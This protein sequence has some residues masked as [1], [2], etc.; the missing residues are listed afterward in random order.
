MKLVF[1]IIGV[2]CLI[3]TYKNFFSPHPR[4]KV[5]KK[6][7]EACDYSINNPYSDWCPWDAD[8]IDG[9]CVETKPIVVKAVVVVDEEVIV[10]KKREEPS[11]IDLIWGLF[12]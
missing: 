8:C 7:G 2:L 10:K 6:L 9:I 5:L 3:Q 4:K 1:Y 12:K 11:T